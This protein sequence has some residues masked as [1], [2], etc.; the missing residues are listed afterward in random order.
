M[1]AIDLRKKTKCQE[2]LRHMKRDAD[3][4]GHCCVWL[5]IVFTNETERHRERGG[6]GEKE[7]DELDGVGAGFWK[8]RPC[9]DRR[10]TR[11]KLPVPAATSS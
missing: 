2:A 5:R 6:K 1:T 7:S 9:K 8:D 10:R 11:A 4:A 3:A